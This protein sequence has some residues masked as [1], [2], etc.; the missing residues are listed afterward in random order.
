[1][2]PLSVVS[3]KQR[4]LLVLG[5]LWALVPVVLVLAHP[6]TSLIIVLKEIVAVQQQTGAILNVLVVTMVTFPRFAIQ[7]VGTPRVCV[8]KMILLGYLL[9]LQ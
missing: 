5:L 9:E 6:P 3:H 1:V 8:C 4:V 2:T 7:V